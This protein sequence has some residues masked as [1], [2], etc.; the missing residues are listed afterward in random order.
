MNVNH[1]RDVNQ[2]RDNRIVIDYRKLFKP[3]SYVKGMDEVMMNA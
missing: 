2:F 1:F 3:L